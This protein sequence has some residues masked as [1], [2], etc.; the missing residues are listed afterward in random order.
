MRSGGNMQHITTILKVNTESSIQHCRHQGI[1]T[2]HEIH[3]GHILCNETL[4]KAGSPR[5]K[6]EIP[7]NQLRTH[8]DING[9]HRD[10]LAEII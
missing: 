1:W 10:S 2:A 6:V 3:A 5:S 7:Q 9:E 4:Y 8:I